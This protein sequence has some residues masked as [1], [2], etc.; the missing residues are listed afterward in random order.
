M[1]SAV[2]L[3]DEAGLLA[4]VVVKNSNPKLTVCNIALDVAA[5]S[6]GRA[7]AQQQACRRS[8]AAGFNNSGGR[9]QSSIFTRSKAFSFL[10]RLSIKKTTFIYAIE[11]NLAS[12][13]GAQAVLIM[14]GVCN[15][16]HINLIRSDFGIFSHIHVLISILSSMFNIYNRSVRHRDRCIVMNGRT[17]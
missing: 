15:I 5:L 17:D 2:E 10:K 1:M 11:Q 6:S 8:A 9:I 16:F 3:S 4:L 13:T 7:G 14:E 12:A